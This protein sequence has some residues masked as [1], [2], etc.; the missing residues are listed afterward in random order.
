MNPKK[1]KPLR[2]ISR[3]KGNRCKFCDEII[4]GDPVRVMGIVIC[5]PCE[6]NWLKSGD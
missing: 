1:N 3:S 5:K 6:K 2:S 4:D